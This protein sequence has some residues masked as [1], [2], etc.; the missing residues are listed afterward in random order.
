M[1]RK[2]TIIDPNAE[3]V[4]AKHLRKGDVINYG[5]NQVLGW[6]PKEGYKPL[7]GEIIGI[8][9]Q[10][11]QISIKTASGYLESCSVNKKFERVKKT[12]LSER[13][14]RPVLQTPRTKREKYQGKYFSID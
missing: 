9:K 10:D 5:S 12:E 7:Q 1:P 13:E 2:R 4:E 11:L 6:N 14:S 3:L 8:W